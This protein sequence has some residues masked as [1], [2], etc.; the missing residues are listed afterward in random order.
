M[1]G[2]APL[3]I[4]LFSFVAAVGIGHVTYPYGQFPLIS[5]LIVTLI[6]SSVFH[7]S[8]DT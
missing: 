5:L 1:I 2:I 6:L 7:L 8:M 3:V 4:F